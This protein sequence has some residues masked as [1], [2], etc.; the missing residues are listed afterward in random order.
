MNALKFRSAICII[1]LM[2]TGCQTQ[3]EKSKKLHFTNN[4]FNSNLSRHYR[5]FS[6]EE[7]IK[8]DW[9]DSE[10]FAKKSIEAANNL[11]VL[12]ENP[13]NWNIKDPIAKK[14]VLLAYEVLNSFLNEESKRLYPRQ[15]AQAQFNYDCWV[16]EL[17]EGWQKEDIKKCKDNFLISINAMNKFNKHKV[18]Y[19]FGKADLN[20]NQIEQ[21]QKFIRAQNIGKNCTINIE[22]HTD[23]TGEEEYNNKLSLLRAQNVAQVIKGYNSKQIKGHGY[24]RNLI[25]TDKGVKEK[26]NR[27][28]EIFISCSKL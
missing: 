14:E 25:K 3:L 20:T 1:I 2:L 28:V 26:K 22:G 24:K 12:P 18:F 16:E 6:E 15:L 27:R 17:E 21:I 5:N 23:Y 9:S 13:N 19:D 8:H 10:H 4:D 7:A 11:N